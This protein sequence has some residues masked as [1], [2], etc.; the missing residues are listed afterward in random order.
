MR[1][2]LS[3]NAT[4][5]LL[6]LFAVSA[7]CWGCGKRTN[8]DGSVKSGAE[9]SVK[10]DWRRF[11]PT[12]TTKTHHFNVQLNSEGEVREQKIKSRVVE[13]NEGDFTIIS[14]DKAVKYLI[15]KDGI[16][17]I[18][19]GN[20]IIKEPIVKGQTWD[21]NFGESK[22]VAKI[23]D[24]AA[25]LAVG[26]KI[27]KPCLVIEESIEEEGGTLINSTWYALDV[28]VVGMQTKAVSGGKE[29]YMLK[30]ELVGLE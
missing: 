18:A 27:Y 25:V 20:Y 13:V 14:E 3:N 7:A 21:L 26:D 4:I 16:R 12:D 29:E 28:G 9:K 1:A 22:G 6:I 10:Y 11:F 19:S 17:R 15:E 23:T 30:A 2:K 24:V 5:I 8:P